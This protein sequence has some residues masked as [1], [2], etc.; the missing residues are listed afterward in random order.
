MLPKLFALSTICRFVKFNLFQLIILIIPKDLIT[1]MIVD[2]RFNVLK[3]IKD[4][5]WSRNEINELL[6]DEIDFTQSLILN[7]YSTRSFKRSSMDLIIRPSELIVVCSF[8]TIIECE[9]HLL[10]FEL[11]ISV[12]LN[13]D[14]F[15]P[16]SFASRRACNSE[17]DLK[18]F[19]LWLS[20]SVR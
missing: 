17:K 18:S 12:C 9:W 15:K 3:T 2:Q 14:I 10:F 4:I 8:W 11:R 5:N 19:I 6:V 1:W 16:F 13:L 7:Q 20:S